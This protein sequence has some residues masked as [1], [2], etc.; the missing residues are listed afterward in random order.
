M[1]LHATGK[2]ETT[3]TKGNKI[4]ITTIEW[5]NSRPRMCKTCRE[6]RAEDKS[7]RC[8]NCTKKYKMQLATDARLRLKVEK[9]L[10]T[11]KHV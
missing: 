1:K 7:S 6:A 8:S 4:E 3:D 10:Q 11:T 2:K 5:R 9:Q